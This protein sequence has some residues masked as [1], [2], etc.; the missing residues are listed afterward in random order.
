MRTLRLIGSVIMVIMMSLNF[1]ACSDDDENDNRP[2]AEKLIGHWY[3]LMRKGL[4][5][6]LN[7]LNMMKH[8]AMRL[9][10]NVNIS[11]T[12]PLGKTVLIVNMIWTVQVTRRVLRNGK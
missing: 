2:L 10:M 6:T 1:I 4:R 5:R 3:L 8:G 9:K 12:S 11:V 7:T